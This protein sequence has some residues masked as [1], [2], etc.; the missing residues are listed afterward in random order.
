VRPFILNER[1]QWVIH[2]TGPIDFD[3]Q[4]QLG[5]SPTI[6]VLLNETDGYLRQ[7][8]IEGT[9]RVKGVQVPERADEGLLC[10]FFS[11]GEVADQCEA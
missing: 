3:C 6:L 2:R 4:W 11:G 5:R 7:P 9:T 8:W 1:G 10:H